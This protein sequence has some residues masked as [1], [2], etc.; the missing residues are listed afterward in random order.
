MTDNSIQEKVSEENLLE[1]VKNNFNPDNQLKFL[2]DIKYLNKDKKKEDLFNSATNLEFSVLERRC[3]YD[4]EG[5]ECYVVVSS[6]KQFFWNT[7]FNY[8]GINF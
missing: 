8:W 4:F 7:N 3:D 2:N 6:G 5:N 1:A